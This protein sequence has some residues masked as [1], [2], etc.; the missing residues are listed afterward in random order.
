M[1]DTRILGAESHPLHL[2]GF[3]FFVVGRGFGNFDPSKDPKNFNLVD[4]IER[5]TVGVPSA[6]VLFMHCHLEVH[7]SWGLK[8][9][10]LVLDGKLPNQK[11]LPP[12]ADLP[13][14]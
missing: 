4:P 5:N 11:L 10:W 3:N 2:Q 13:K 1:Q 8:M 9:A 6:G 12:P 14:C 7:A